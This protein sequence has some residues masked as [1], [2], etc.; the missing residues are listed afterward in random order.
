MSRRRAR[1]ITFKY[2]YSMYFGDNNEENTVDT[3]L[4]VNE[5]ELIPLEQDE[6][7]FLDLAIKG[8]KD[9]LE[10]IDDRIL[11]KLKNWTK[12]RI[13]KVDLAILRLAVYELEYDK[14]VPYKV[15][16]NEA[17]E[18]AKKYGNDESYTFVNGVLREIY[19]ESEE[20]K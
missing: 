1:D 10:K 17:V 13:F 8:I 2:V 12:K 3:I 6:R 20:E 15:V 5:E 14:S 9:N 4:T 19:A 18:L 7:A 16:I 11:S